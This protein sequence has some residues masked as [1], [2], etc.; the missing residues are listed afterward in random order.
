MQTKC[1]KED[2]CLSRRSISSE[3]LICIEQT[4]NAKKTILTNGLNVLNT[5]V[6]PLN[7]A[8]LAL[9]ILT[10]RLKMVVHDRRGIN[11]NYLATEIKNE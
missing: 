5:S 10:M 6:P 3:V 2:L 8:R 1:F 9:L 7:L 4:L 11:L